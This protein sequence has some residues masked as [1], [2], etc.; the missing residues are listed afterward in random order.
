MRRVAITRDISPA[1]VDCEL[2][3][4]ARVP[5]DVEI[6]RAQ[7]LAYERALA[8]AGYVI[9]RLSAGADMPD[10]VFVEDIAVV[11][12]EL[13]IIT[14]PGAVSRRAETPAVAE[15]L[16]RF[17]PLHAIEPPGVLDGGDVLVVGRRVFVGVSTRTNRTA[18]AQMRDVLTP[19]GY[20][21]CEVDVRGCLH[22]KS[23]VT[24]V[25]DSLLLVNPEW[26]PMAAF[27]GFE[28]VTVDRGEP[29]AANALQLHDR[30]IFPTSFPRTAERLAARGLRIARVDASELAKAEGAV[31]CCSVIVDSR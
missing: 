17:R 25:G 16:A 3:H 5:I 11:F 18:I 1:I 4:L 23:A 28:Y 13:A 10:S 9:E 12:D 30:I 21:V 22:L 31:T 2:T 14:R 6:V 24:A 8:E 7:H 19:L 29:T 20:S 26:A 15:A 27:A